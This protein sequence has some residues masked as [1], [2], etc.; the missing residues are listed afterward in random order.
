MNSWMNDFQEKWYEHYNSKSLKRTTWLSR[1][2]FNWYANNAWIQHVTIYFIATRNIFPFEICSKQITAK[3]IHVSQI[4]KNVQL[5][6]MKQKIV[7]T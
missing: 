5:V 3:Y 7:P 2:Y 6:L 4:M 1:I